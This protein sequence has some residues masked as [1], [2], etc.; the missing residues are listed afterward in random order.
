MKT[1]IFYKDLSIN[2]KIN[3]KSFGIVRCRPEFG[4]FYVMANECKEYGL[5]SYSYYLKQT[6]HKVTFE[7]PYNVFM[8]T[9]SRR[10]VING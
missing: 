8:Q 5:D 2:E 1:E 4:Y 3:H 6:T 7:M 10:N 9:Y